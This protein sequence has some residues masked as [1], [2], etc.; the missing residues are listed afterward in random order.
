MNFDSS[1][2]EFHRDPAFDTAF[3]SEFDEVSPR[4]AAT[5]VDH[6]GLLALANE[7][8][9]DVALIEGAMAHLELREFAS[10]NA[11]IDVLD[12]NASA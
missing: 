5:Q 11:A 4:S 10:V 1:P 6:Q 9:R 2:S 3:T 12:G 8:E 7:L